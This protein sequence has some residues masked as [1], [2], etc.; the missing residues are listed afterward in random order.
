MNPNEKNGTERITT[1]DLYLQHNAEVLQD[2]A[3][4]EHW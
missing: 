4:E 3:I 2:I 1:F